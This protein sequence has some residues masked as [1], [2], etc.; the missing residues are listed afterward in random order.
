[1][2]KDIRNF[3][4][5]VFLFLISFYAAFIDGMSSESTNSVLFEQELK[6]I[7]SVIDQADVYIESRETNQCF[8]DEGAAC[9]A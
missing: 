4:F 5:I 9:H 2:S 1:M 8:V 3:S 7:E 6:V